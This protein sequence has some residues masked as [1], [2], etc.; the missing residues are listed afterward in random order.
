MKS[1]AKKRSIVIGGH[2]T[3]ISLE[4]PFWT[5]LKEI[6]KQRD[7]T[8]SELVKGIDTDR[9]HDNLSSAVRL[10]VLAAHHTETVGDHDPGVSAIPVTGFQRGDVAVADG[11]CEQPAIPGQRARAD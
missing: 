7:V 2:K 3:S 5:A 10:F 11:V 9:E 4:E 6:A 8:L 1:L